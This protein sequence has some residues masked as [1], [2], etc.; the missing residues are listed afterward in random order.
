MSLLDRLPSRRRRRRRRLIENTSQGT[1]AAFWLFAGTMHF[2]RPDLYEKIMPP[3][4]PWH[5][6]LVYASGVAELA[7]GAGVLVPRARRYAGWWLLATL[8]AV[9][10]A[11]IHMTAN[12]DDPNW[13]NVPNVLLWMRLPL[14]ALAALW[15]WRATQE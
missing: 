3:Y 13:R 7:G 12:P 6:E 11:N 14:Q 15:I 2:V 5:R 8:L 10:P 4:L 1:L 9:F